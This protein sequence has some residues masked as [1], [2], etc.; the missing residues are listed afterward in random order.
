MSEISC[1]LSYLWCWL[2]SQEVQSEAGHQ[3]FSFHWEMTDENFPPIRMRKTHEIIMIIK[4]MISIYHYENM[5][6]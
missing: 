4:I 3:I 6:I 2:L 5:P 1:E